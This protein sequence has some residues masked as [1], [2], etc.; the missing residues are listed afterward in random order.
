MT[1]LDVSRC[2]ICNTEIVISESDEHPMCG[3]VN[4][5]KMAFPDD[6]KELQEEIL[7]V[8]A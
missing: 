7:S 6:W 8:K 1:N 4:C 5:F 2:K 3:R